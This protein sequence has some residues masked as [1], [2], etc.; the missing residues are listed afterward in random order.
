MTIYLWVG[1]EDTALWSAAITTELDFC[2]GSPSRNCTW[3]YSYIVD[4][5]TVRLMTMGV[6]TY[7]LNFLRVLLAGVPIM[8]WIFESWSSSLDPGKRG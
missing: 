2:G 3:F 4:I 6:H 5:S 1:I 8:S 7:C